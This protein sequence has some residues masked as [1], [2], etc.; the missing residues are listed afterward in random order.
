MNNKDLEEDGGAMASG[1]GV[2]P[3]NN[4]GSG[5]IAGINPPAV[6]LK[7]K[8]FFAGHKVFEV[9]GDRFEK[10]RLGKK[11]Y[12]RYENYVGNDDL[13]EE[14]RQYGRNNPSQPIILQHDKTGQMCFL[15]YGKDKSF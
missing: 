9:D 13:G 6:M 3:A 4:V 15:R 12:L 5:N 8:K 2:V 7:R 10:A 14:I 1:G 11:K